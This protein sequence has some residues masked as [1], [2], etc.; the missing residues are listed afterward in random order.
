[1]K[2]KLQSSAAEIAALGS[3]QHSGSSQTGHMFSS[4]VAVKANLMQ[5]S[6]RSAKTTPLVS[7]AMSQ[8]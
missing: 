5:Q 2:E 7:K 1:L 8:I 6:S 3:L 4:L